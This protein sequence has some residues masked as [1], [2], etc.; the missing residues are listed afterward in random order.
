MGYTGVITYL[1]TIYY[2]FLGHP[3]MVYL[4]TWMVDFY[5]Q[6]IGKYT[7]PMD[8]MG[9]WLVF[10]DPCKSCDYVW[11]IPFIYLD[12]II[13]YITQPIGVKWSLLMRDIL[14]C[15]DGFFRIRKD[16]L[17]N[18]PC[19]NFK[20]SQSFPNLYFGLFRQGYTHHLLTSSDIWSI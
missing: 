17:I 16:H 4:P 12:S 8:P 13:P 20:S 1:Q 18:T 7:I 19:P 2:N 3:W 15:P 11:N 6:C 14:G 5:G 10:R 9:Y